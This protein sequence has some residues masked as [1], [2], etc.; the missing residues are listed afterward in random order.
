M[1]TFVWDAL[2]CEFSSVF[3]ARIVA[4]TTEKECYQA[5]QRRFARLPKY[6]TNG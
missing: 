1:L 2:Q 4:A 5:I 6:P 3:G